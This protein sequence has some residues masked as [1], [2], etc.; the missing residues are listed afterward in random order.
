[1]TGSELTRAAEPVA[2]IAPDWVIIG[3]TMD[4]GRVMLLASSELGRANLTKV[5]ERRRE[6]YRMDP[7]GKLELLPAEGMTL[8]VLMGHYV[9][10]MGRDY[11]DALRS[12]FA[13]WSPDKRDGIP[14]LPAGQ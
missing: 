8:D 13:H 7:S 1:M 14:E 10:V 12:L 6:S 3:A 5:L 9:W 2:A 4:D 11:A